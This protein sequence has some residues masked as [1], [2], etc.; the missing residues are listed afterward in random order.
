[1]RLGCPSECQPDKVILDVQ[2]ERTLCRINW[3]ELTSYSKVEA[4]ILKLI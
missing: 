4:A 3:P 1:M 2:A